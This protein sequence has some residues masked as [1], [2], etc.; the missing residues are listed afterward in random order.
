[1]DSDTIIGWIMGMVVGLIFLFLLSLIPLALL[2]DHL[3]STSNGQHTGYVTAVEKNGLIWK[4]WTAY[5]KTD[6]QSSQEDKY[7]VTD[8]S[9]VAELK[10]ASQTR[11]L[12][13]VNFDQ[14]WLVW[15]MQCNSEGAIITGLSTE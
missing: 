2:V 4:T 5:I 13:T 9:V 6:P 1:M 15:K 3:G 12:I 14:P 10:K 7:C 8:E 11:E